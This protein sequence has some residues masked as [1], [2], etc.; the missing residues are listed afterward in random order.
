MS[1]TEDADR[2]LSLA[3]ERMTPEFSRDPQ[4][5]YRKVLEQCPVL[6]S[7]GSVAVAS[8]EL[9]EF[10]LRHPELFTSDWG[11]G[12]GLGNERPLIPLQIDPPKHKEYRKLLDP[13]FAPREM[14]KL[15]A[16][17]A[18]LTNEIIDVFADRGGCDFNEEFAVPLPTTVF[19]RLL[20]L[21][22][23]ERPL[24]LKWKDAIIRPPEG[25]D[26][27]ESGPIRKAAADE[28][29]A[30]FLKMLD[31]RETDPRDDLLT[32]FLNSE[33]EGTRL[34]RDEILDIC[35]LL[36]IAGLDTVT[37]ALDC[38]FAYL[39]QHPEHRRQ[40]V[41]DPS[42]IP[43]A[44]EELLRWETV[45][46]G[47]ARFARIDTEIAGCPV[48]KGD[49]VSVMLGSANV[50]ENAFP[51]PFTVD[52]GRD[53]NKHLA[54]GGGIHRC[55]GSHLA[56]LELRVAFREW[57]RRIPDY[58]VPDGVELAYTAGLRQ[59]ERFPLVFS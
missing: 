51:D 7:E 58:H 33:V 4:S 39:A 46:P 3:L 23:E 5:H 34:T 48:A 30:Y 56:R 52:F 50:D 42:V 43:S 17:V 20:G 47:V 10:T 36:L 16:D 13:L 49:A 54:F 41:D 40:I 26:F 8:H 15:E 1:Q 32:G 24:F 27:E 11:D 6:P 18:R 59:I 37:D 45:V 29:Y 14:A 55:L 19:L 53:P 57:H 44:I 28:M 38:S 31:L 21:P 2:L 9:V 25:I 35:F 12:I 22:I